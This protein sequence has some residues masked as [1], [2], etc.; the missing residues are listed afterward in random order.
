MDEATRAQL[1]HWLGDPAIALIALELADLVEEVR[2][3][4]EELRGGVVT[5]AMPGQLNAAE[6][7]RMVDSWD[8]SERPREPTL[9]IPEVTNDVHTTMIAPDLSHVRLT[10]QQGSF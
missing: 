7:Q 5:R 10:A 1:K 4:R 2:A 3:L 6:T 8:C 9:V